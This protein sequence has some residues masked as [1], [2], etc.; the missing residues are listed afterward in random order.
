VA[1]E[2]CLQMLS[3][4]FVQQ[5]RRDALEALRVLKAEVF[6]VEPLPEFKLTVAFSKDLDD[7]GLALQI[8]AEVNADLR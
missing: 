8:A 2:H 1:I 7:A 4:Q 5:K 3:G 6:A